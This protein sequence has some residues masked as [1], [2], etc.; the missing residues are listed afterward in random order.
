MNSHFSLLCAQISSPA[1]DFLQYLKTQS[2]AQVHSCMNIAEHSETAP[3]HFLPQIY[4]VFQ[5]RWVHKIF[6]GIVG[7]GRPFEK[8]RQDVL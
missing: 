8:V 4:T 5:Q 1:L 3:G 6:H 7:V 2:L